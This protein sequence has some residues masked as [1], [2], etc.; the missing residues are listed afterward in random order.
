MTEATYKIGE[1]ARAVG[2]PTSTVRYYE[3]AGLLRPLRRSARNYRQYDQR[4]VERLRFI[5]TAQA[6]GFTLEDVATLVELCDQRTPPN[7]RVQELLD[8]RIEEVDRRIDALR[9]LREVLANS[10]ASCRE[11]ERDGVC[12]VLDG[13]RE[14]ES[15]DGKR[16]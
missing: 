9:R 15:G 13:F 2:V 8:R 16:R 1:L 3:R 14:G 7:A 5:R 6:S 10:L 12:P 4:A 11:R